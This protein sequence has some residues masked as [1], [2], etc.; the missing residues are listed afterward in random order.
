[1]AAKKKSSKD[2]EAIAAE[3]IHRPSELTPH[4]KL[5]IYSRNK[6][7]K[8]KFCLSAPDVLVADPE[9]GTDKYIK[10]DPHVWPIETWDDLD[11]FYKYLRTGKHDYQWCALDGTTRMH[12]MALNKVMKLQEEKDLDRIPG[13]VRRQDYGKA[14]E[15]SKRMFYNFLNL[16]MGVIFTAQERRVEIDAEDDEEGVD[17]S[18][19]QY[20]PDL[21]KG[22]KSAIN[23]I[24]DVIGRMTVVKVKVR[25]KGE[26]KIRVVNQRRLFIG[27][28]DNYDTG[29]RSDYDLPEQ[30]K[31][32][33]VPK[34]VN[35]IMT[36]EEK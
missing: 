4:P 27:P 16:P 36:G 34:L 24:V 26:K 5:L 2:Y 17:A 28:H 18:Q 15:L 11:D 13:I 3:K 7:G 31:N 23:G 14:G 21:P 19:T 20:V 6:I 8:T 32:P 9:H 30:V 10:Q 25:K 12:N 35:L 1:M 22:T 33:T 29:F